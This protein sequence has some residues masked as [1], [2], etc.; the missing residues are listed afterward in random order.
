MGQYAAR[1]SRLLI[2]SIESYETMPTIKPL[3]GYNVRF[4]QDGIEAVV[5][6]VDEERGILSAVLVDEK[7]KQII[8]FHYPLGI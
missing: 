6:W 1:H 3:D 7:R 8:R 5:G 4:F 2:N